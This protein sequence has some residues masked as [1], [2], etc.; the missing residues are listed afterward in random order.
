M[1][2]PPDAATAVIEAS[3]RQTALLGHEQI[4]TDHLLLALLDDPTST[5][6]HILTDLVTLP[7][8][9]MREHLQH[10][11][12]QQPTRPHPPPPHPTQQRRIH[13]RRR[14][15]PHRRPE[16]R[17]LRCTPASPTPSTHP[18]SRSSRGGRQ[19]HRCDEP[20]QQRHERAHPRAGRRPHSDRRRCR[21]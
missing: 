7:I 3:L 12:P 1:S 4:G 9:D 14:R 11:Q 6:T 15:R 10:E 20:R 19:L 17:N 18:N 8:G 2:E 5:G 16:P 13:P 21:P